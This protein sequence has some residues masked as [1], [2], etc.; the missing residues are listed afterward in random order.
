MIPEHF[1]LPGR[2]TKQG[3]R[4]MLFHM[5]YSKARSC[6]IEQCRIT[7][8]PDRVLRLDRYSRRPNGAQ[9][10]DTGLKP[11]NEGLPCCIHTVL[12]KHHRVAPEP[13][14]QHAVNMTIFRKRKG[15]R[16]GQWRAEIHLPPTGTWLPTVSSVCSNGRRTVPVA[17]SLTPN[18][19]S[20][21]RGSPTPLR[22]SD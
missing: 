19:R 14:Y 13:L 16:L 20:E 9:V 17:A 6:C 18:A 8:R 22:C 5:C 2:L 3:E 15:K 21:A 10:G 11:L 1:P 4:E 12:V 7:L